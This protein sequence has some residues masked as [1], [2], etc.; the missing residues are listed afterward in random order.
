MTGGVRPPAG[1]V[2][3]S[4]DDQ[5]VHTDM[6]LPPEVTA[7]LA[8]FKGERPPAPAWF[9]EA[10][11]Q[12]PERS[13]VESNGTK[14]ELLTWGEVGKPGLLLLHGNSAHA[15]WWSHIAPFLAE[16][17]RVAAM[18][19]AGMGNSEWRPHYGFDLFAA[20]ALACA[21][22]AQLDASG[23]QPIYVGHSF[24]GA[25]VFYTAATHPEHMR[26]A[27]L[28]DC[29][30]SGPPPEAQDR[31]QRRADMA[32][33]NPELVS[34]RVYPTLAAALARFRLMP[35]QVAGAIYVADFIARGSLR[36]APM[37]DG[38]GM[39]WTW[40]FDPEMWAKL[41]RSGIED[42]RPT[43]D[44]VLKVPLAHLLGDRSSLVERRL[45]GEARHLPESAPEIAIPDSAHHVMVDQ[46]LAL[47][48]ALRALL[49]SWP[50]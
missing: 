17:Y 41:D 22:A 38:S 43:R 8:S 18:S 5:P 6:D 47:V 25:Q 39:G 50:A 9:D 31:L 35:P 21:R 28:I 33:T 16:D 49:A 3:P 10:L 15:D 42:L 48:A 23:R 11:A 30:L 45:A 36:E 12:A 1:T 2:A 27:V 29:G 24:G 37:A 32:R 13:F 26:A 34:S 7:P 46:P 14:V 40:K 4:Y 44:V 19:L 20:D